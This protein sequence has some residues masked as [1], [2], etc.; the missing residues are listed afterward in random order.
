MSKLSTPPSS[1]ISTRGYELLVSSD[2]LRQALLPD[3]FFTSPYE[4]LDYRSKVVIVDSKGRQAHFFRQHELRFLHDGPTAI[5]DHLWGDGLLLDY[6]NSAGPVVDGIRDGPCK[7]LVIDL[8]R[9]VKKGQRLLVETRRTTLGSFTKPQE[10]MEI[11][12]DHPVHQLTRVV[13]FP[14]ERPC[15]EAQVSFGSNTQKLVIESLS[16]GESLLRL[17]VER[18]KMNVVYRL[19]WEW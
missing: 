18:P 14:R 15:Q 16:S 5:L 12:V 8:G 2:R 13:V 17:R 1:L 11:V 3:G 7:H 19:A 4:V 10:W 6:Q 9:P